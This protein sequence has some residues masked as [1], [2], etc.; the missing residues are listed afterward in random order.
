MDVMILY[1]RKSIFIKHVMCVMVL[2]N[3]YIYNRK[4]FD[5]NA[6]VDDLSFL[7][8]HFKR[9]IVYV[10][11]ITYIRGSCIDAVTTRSICVCVCIGT[12][13]IVR[14]RRGRLSGWRH[15]LYFYLPTLQPHTKFSKV[16]SFPSI[17]RLPST[18]NYKKIY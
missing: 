1:N 8:G 10:L 17:H 18:N 7:P 9:F 16:Q 6:H 13:F 14:M 2:L 5:I 3:K 15:P 11:N 12:L 4:I